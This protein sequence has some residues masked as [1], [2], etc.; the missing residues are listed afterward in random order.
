M[1]FHLSHS[2]QIT[3][4]ILCGL[5]TVPIDNFQTYQLCW[6]DS[7]KGEDYWATRVVLL[8]KYCFLAKWKPPL[9]KIENSVKKEMKI[10]H[11][12]NKIKNRQTQIHTVAYVWIYFNVCAL[13]SYFILNRQSVKWAKITRSIIQW[14]TKREKSTNISQ[15]TQNKQ[16]EN[17]TIRNLHCFR[18]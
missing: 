2:I 18:F 11:K 14:I 13:A 1:S 4:D 17:K 15:G 3:S 8:S 16:S 5:L 10:K 7:R 9:E 12:Q 6:L